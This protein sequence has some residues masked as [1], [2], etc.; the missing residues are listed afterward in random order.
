MN[1]VQRPDSYEAADY[2]GVLRRRWW[3]VLA[4]ACIG[5]VG[6]FGYVTVA[7]KAYTAT[8][9]VYVAATAADQGGQLANSRILFLGGL[10]C[11]HNAMCGPAARRMRK[12]RGTPLRFR[13]RA[14]ALCTP[15]Y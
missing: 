11:T 9:T 5:L 13:Q 4:G 14:K 6:A 1:P 8:A 2:T 15:S 12:K 3:I 7:P 10:R